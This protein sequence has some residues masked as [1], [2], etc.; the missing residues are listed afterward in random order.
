M[1]V[2]LTTIQS[3]AQ[4]HNNGSRIR[5]YILYLLTQIVVKGYATV[6]GS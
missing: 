6:L 3:I 4:V 2:D 5:V 1:P